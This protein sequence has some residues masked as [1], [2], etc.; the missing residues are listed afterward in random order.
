MRLPSSGVAFS[1]SHTVMFNEVYFTKQRQGLVRLE[2]VQ[3]DLVQWNALKPSQ[4]AVDFLQ[5][6]PRHLEQRV[7]AIRLVPLDCLAML[8]EFLPKATHLRV[9]ALVCRKWLAASKHVSLWN[10]F[11]MEHLATSSGLPLPNGVFGNAPA[12]RATFWLRQLTEGRFS[13]ARSVALSTTSSIHHR[14]VSQFLNK[15]P[16]VTLLDFSHCDDFDDTCLASLAAAPCCTPKERFGSQ[17][18]ETLKLNFCVKFNGHTLATMPFSWLRVLEV[19]GCAQLRDEDFHRI[20]T[21]TAPHLHELKCRSANITAAALRDIT[22][23]LQLRVLHLP[24]CV[25]VDESLLGAVGRLCPQLI[26][27]SLSSCARQTHDKQNP[28]K[29]HTEEASY[30]HLTA[31]LLD[32]C[33]QLSDSSLRTLPAVFRGMKRLSVDRTRLTGGALVHLLEEWPCLESIAAAGCLYARKDVAASAIYRNA[34]AA[35]RKTLSP[36]SVVFFGLGRQAGLASKAP[37]R[38]LSS[39][40]M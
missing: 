30:R 31:L 15:M 14:D 32:G 20:L 11:S 27:L 36:P 29:R 12:A 24:M 8:Y 38:R 21:V 17:T 33:Q 23:A 22:V 4:H 37:R 1:D 34:L 6:P 26:E 28:I 5:S 10:R 16:M 25:D 9:L 13:T 19:S 18:L 40:S 7:C 39:L 3:D 2:R 35:A